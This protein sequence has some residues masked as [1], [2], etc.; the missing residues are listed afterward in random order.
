MIKV[1]EK[2]MKGLKLENERIMILG[3]SK[4]EEEEKAL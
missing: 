1:I 3:T 4:L 2:Q